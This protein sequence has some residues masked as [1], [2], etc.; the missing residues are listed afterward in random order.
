MDDKTIVDIDA[1]VNE[2]W[3]GLIY[4]I[5]NM[6][7][8]TY[9]NILKDK[10]GMALE[11]YENMISGDIQITP[12]QT[13][14][15]YDYAYKTGLYKDYNPIQEYYRREVLKTLIKQI[16]NETIIDLGCEDGR[17]SIGLALFGK[18]TVHGIDM[19]EYAI[20]IAEHKKDTYPEIKD[21]VK[22]HKA[23]YNSQDFYEYIKKTI[24]EGADKVVFVQPVSAWFYAR[25]KVNDILK[26]E[27]NIV[28]TMLHHISC[29]DN[30]K[31]KDRI[32]MDWGTYAL[33]AGM[34]YNIIEYKPFYNRRAILIGEMKR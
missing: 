31:E 17:I 23:D 21:K 24:P 22:F 10:Y 6:D 27:G 28:V 12:A 2:Y 14:E 11:E 5:N 32:M 13:K 4:D 8:P 26:P 1:K 29:E 33:R 18:N 15:I 7:I 9:M 19:N 34:S 3:D 20:D 25:H 30:A 16:S